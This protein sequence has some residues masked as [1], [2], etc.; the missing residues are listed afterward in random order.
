MRTRP[1]LAYPC[2]ARGEVSRHGSGERRDGLLG[3]TR[4]PLTTGLCHAS[5]TTAVA[6][7]TRGVALDREKG[8]RNDS[9]TAR[10]PE[11]LR[12]WDGELGEPYHKQVQRQ[13]A[14]AV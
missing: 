13:R 7:E 12:G 6:T 11:E 2:G 14:S 9:N 4:C 10:W 3:V 1:W 5:H 8:E